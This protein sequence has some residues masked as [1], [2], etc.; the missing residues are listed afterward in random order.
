MMCSGWKTSGVSLGSTSMP[1][2]SVATAASSRSKIQVAVSR[3]RPGAAPPAYA[4]H[5]PAS[6]HWAIWPV[7]T[8]TMSPRPTVTPC[9]RTQASRS[10]TWI[11]VTGLEPGNAAG[12]GHVEQ[13]AAAD[14]PLA[15][16]RDVVADGA[17]APDVGRVV[18]V[19]DLAVEDDVGQRV[20]LGA[21]LQRQD[22]Q[23]VGAADVPVAA[24]VEVAHGRPRHGA[25]AVADHEVDR[26]EAAEAA[27]LRPALVD[28]DGQRDDPPVRRR[29]GWRPRR[30]RAGCGSA[31]RAGRPGPS[32]PSSSS[33][34]RAAGRCRCPAA[35]GSG[36]PRRA[37][38]SSRSRT[39]S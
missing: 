22:E 17:L 34:R 12:A 10:A 28:R 32:D 4:P 3:A 19:V 18:A 6:R 5:R 2:V 27:G 15:G 39:R 35:R 9:A 29:A 30:P 38:H 11:G 16:D 1:H 26:V 25:I 14:D 23:V 24:A 37:A 21:R 13:D 31:S 20:P 36:C 33:A 8:R 7:R